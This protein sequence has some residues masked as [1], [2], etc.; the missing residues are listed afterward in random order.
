ME[1]ANAIA[2]MINVAASHFFAFFS[3]LSATSEKKID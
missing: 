1:I 2:P 3:S